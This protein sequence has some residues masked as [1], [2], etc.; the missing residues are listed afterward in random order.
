MPAIGSSVVAVLRERASLKPNSTAFTFIDYQQD[1]LGVA[2]SL[3]WAQLYR[4]VLNVARQLSVC[5]LAGGRPAKLGPRGRDYIAAFLGAMQAGLVAVPLSVP[6]KGA[7]DDRVISVLRDTS[8]SG[9]LTTSA[10]VDDVSEY[11]KPQSGESAPAIVEVDL[12]D[13]DARN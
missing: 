7:H 6:F 5:G 13:E 4:R 8:P 11:A 12:L 2:A 9:I 1:W 10:V 3:T